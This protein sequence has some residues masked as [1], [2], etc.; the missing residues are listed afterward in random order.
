[1]NEVA[2]KTRREAEECINLGMKARTVAAT[3]L[4]GDSSRS[5]AMLT[6]RLFQYTDPKDP[7]LSP[8]LIRTNKLSI[9][10]LAGSERNQRTQTTGTRYE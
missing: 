2:V 3:A 6:I 8:E 4:N 9:V 7:N 1:M 5:H 10:D